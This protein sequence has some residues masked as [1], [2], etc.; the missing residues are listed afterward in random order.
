MKK[1]TGGDF[2]QSPS[3]RPLRVGERVRQIIG[4]A[5]LQQDLGDVCTGTGLTVTG[6]RMS[7]DLRYADV[8]VYALEP[9]SDR[10]VILAELKKRQQDFKKALNDGLRLRCVPALRF[11]WDDSFERGAAMDRLFENDHVKRDVVY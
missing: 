1:V 7:R 2:L 10:A 3:V 8:F 6:V 4:M 11:F 9:V 5:L